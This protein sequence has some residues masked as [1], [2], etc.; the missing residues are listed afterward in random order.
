MRIAWWKFCSAISTVSPY[1][2]FS[3]L[4]LV[5]VC[6][7]RIGAS[8]TDGSSNSRSLGED[9]SA[10]TIASIC[11][12]PPESEPA[13]WRLR[14]ARTG[15]ISNEKARVLPMSGRAA[16]RKAPSRRFSSTLSLGNRRRPSGTMATPR[17]TISSVDRR[18]RSWVFPSRSRLTEPRVGRTMP[19]THF[20]SVLL[21]LPLVPSSATVSP[22][23][24]PMETPCSARTAP[25]RASIPE[26]LSSSAKVGFLH[27]RVLDDLGRRALA[28]DPAGVEADHALREAHHRLHD[29]L[30]HDDRDP[31]RIQVKQYFQNFVDFVAGEPGHRLVGDQQPRPRRHRAREL[32]LAQLD[33]GEQV[34][35]RV[36]F[37]GHPHLPQDCHRLVPGIGGVQR[38]AV[39]DVFER[40]DKVLQ[41]R[42]ALE[43]ARDLDAA[44]DTA[45]RAL[46][47]RQARDLGAVEHD[48]ARF[49]SQCARDTV[50]QGRF[51]RSVRPDQA[52]ALAGGDLQADL[53]QR[54]EAPEMLRH[55]SYLEERWNHF[56]FLSRPSTPSGAATTNTTSSTPTT[57]TLI[58]FEIVT[59]TTC[60]TEPSRI[61][62]ITGPSQCE[63]PPII[64]MAS[65]DTE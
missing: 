25:Y 8:P 19:M 29:V 65:A 6:E 50:D 60:W 20:I 3:S 28:D 5:M 21:P 7:T 63:V 44:C 45:A 16:W 58:S 41:H 37:F 30:D 56:S 12:W 1:R 4:I 34:R 24:I 31:G 55:A 62:P 33:L 10:R 22:W 14:S 39:R 15:K 40:H 52:E 43:R 61:A 42:H 18:V 23:R 36:G 48:R 26:I 9:M 54:G 17:L 53:A 13:S 51:A 59:V 49:V 47:G 27:F 46:V 35:R 38:S 11:C 2:S 32:E 57:S 64:G